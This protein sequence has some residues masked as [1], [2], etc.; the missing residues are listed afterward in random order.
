[1]RASGLGIVGLVGICGGVV[2]LGTM[3][4]LDTESQVASSDAKK[5]YLRAATVACPELLVGKDRQTWITMASI[6]GQPGQSDSGS[7]TLTAA[8]VE[9]P[10]ARITSA[11]GSAEVTGLPANAT[12]AV[13]VAL[14]GLAPGSLVA[15]SSIDNSGEGRGLASAECAPPSSDVWLVGGGSL[16][17]QR[18]RVVLVNPT[19]SDAVVDLDVY[20][21][22]GKIEATGTES[23]AVK[24]KG[25]T[26][27]RLDALVSDV[28]ALAVRAR[29]RVGLVS[30]FIV[31]DRMEELIPRGTEIISDAGSPKRQSLVAGIPGGTGKRQLLLF[32]PARGA[33]VHVRALTADGPVE[34]AN[35]GNVKV[36]RG[37]VITVDLSKDL[38]DKP[39]SLEITSDVAFLATAS[40]QTQEGAGATEARASA[41]S[42]AEAELSKAKGVEARAWATQKISEVKGSHVDSGSDIAW[43]SASRRLTNLG[44]ATAILPSTKTKVSLAAKGGDVKVKISVL[45][46]KDPNGK[47]K[48]Q[49]EVVVA[50]DTSQEFVVKP[51]SKSTYSIVVQRIEG[52]GQ[53]YA[54]QHQTGSGRAITGYALSRLS[55]WVRVP[56]ANEVFGLPG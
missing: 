25:R 3:T 48:L 20:G 49:Q 23:I 40:M 10:L 5:E 1:M 27:V 54:S 44:A 21:P 14:G 13:A 15:R 46:S 35:D 53:L 29:T 51:P 7:F 32:A 31:D 8:E 11:G 6:P 30:A 38:A 4:A 17:G 37:R 39:A 26:E 52:A 56:A 19:D 55:S 47:L 50:G 16:A 12:H 45:D 24:P 36:R 9:E 34:L 18:D 42:A 2:A 33:T 43:F 22:D 41:I 28:A